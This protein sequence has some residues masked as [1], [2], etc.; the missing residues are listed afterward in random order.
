MIIYEVKLFDN[1]APIYG[2][3]SPK[4][5]PEYAPEYKYENHCWYLKEH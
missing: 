2:F 4:N 3:A 5:F 1:S